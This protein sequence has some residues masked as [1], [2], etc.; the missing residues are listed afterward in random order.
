MDGITEVLSRT[1]DQLLGRSSGPLHFRLVLQP[2]VASVIAIKAGLRDA[3]SGQSPFFWS[4]LTKAAERRRLIQ[5][6]WRDIGKVFILALLIDTVYQ[7]FMFR[8]F[9]VLQ[10][11]I[12]AV[13]VAVVPYLILRGLVTRLARRNQAPSSTRRA[14]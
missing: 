3:R 7:L 4:L 5:S 2:I 13:A 14:A 9:Y 8:A 1:V 10:S 6:G 11:L 12:V